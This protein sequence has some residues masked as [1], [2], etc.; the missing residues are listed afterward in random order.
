MR[1][2]KSTRMKKVL[3]NLILYSRANNC[4]TNRVHFYKSKANLTLNKNK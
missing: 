1:R 4:N 2:I 3:D